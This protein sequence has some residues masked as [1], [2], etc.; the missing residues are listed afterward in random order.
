VTGDE[1]AVYA[2]PGPFTAISIARRSI[3]VVFPPHVFTDSAT[4]AT[5]YL[6]KSYYVWA[7]A[8][9]ADQ[10]VTVTPVSPYFTFDPAVWTFSSGNL[11]IKVTATVTGVPVAAANGQTSIS[12]IIGGQNG[13]FYANIDNTPVTLSVRP[14]L[15]DSAVISPDNRVAGVFVDTPSAADFGRDNVYSFVIQSPALP[16]GSLTITPRSRHITFS[17]DGVSIA[18]GG[19]QVTNSTQLKS[20]NSGWGFHVPNLQLFAN[21][22]LTPLSSGVHEV[23][24]ELSGSDAPYY[25]PPPHTFVSVWVEERSPGEVAQSGAASVMV[26]LSV[27]V[28]AILAAIL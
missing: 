5:L 11:Q 15:F 3:Q 22:T 18:N 27:L 17:P 13:G 25:K 24:F 14:L 21:F 6:Q 16:Q 19:A 4:V 2:A 28:F 7:T 23:W 12:Y 8:S 26:S 9:Y 20:I 1:S 10:P